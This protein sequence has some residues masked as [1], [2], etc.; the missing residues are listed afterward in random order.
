[1]VWTWFGHGLDMVLRHGFEF[2]ETGIRAY[3]I[4]KLGGVY[5]L[6]FRKC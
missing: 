2:D 1:M 5:P 3:N 4:V 6:D